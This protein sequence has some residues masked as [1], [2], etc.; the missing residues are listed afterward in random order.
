[1]EV[2]FLQGMSAE[3]A[4]F[5]TTDL[6]RFLRRTKREHPDMFDGSRVLSVG[7]RQLAKIAA[8]GRENASGFLYE[9]TREALVAAAVDL[10][11]VVLDNASKAEIIANSLL[12]HIF[13]KTEGSGKR[14]QKKE[15]VPKKEEAPKK[16]A[17]KKE[18]PKKE[19]PKS[20]GKAPT[21]SLPSKAS[22]VMVNPRNVEDA[23]ERRPA[24]LQ[25]SDK[26][27][28]TLVKA[29]TRTGFGLEAKK[30]ICLICFEDQVNIVNLCCMNS[31]HVQC[32][33]QWLEKGSAS[34][35][36]CRAAMAWQLERKPVPVYN[37]PFPVYF[38]NF[39]GGMA[40]DSEDYDSDGDQDG[41]HFCEVEKK[42]FMLILLLFF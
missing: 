5:S 22:R 10:G 36:S 29:E 6:L 25:K 4:V 13:K 31:F 30:Q 35:P 18:A 16:K 21:K 24:K 15:S 20:G 11:E 8:L 28:S 34:C 7:P 27:Q 38:G 39:R 19:A 14:L 23:D 3:S 12:P 26:T 42:K 2:F 17:P 41:F 32:L 9:F 33:G 1:M 37:N 40:I